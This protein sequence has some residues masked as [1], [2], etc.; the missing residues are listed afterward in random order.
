LTVLIVYAIIN[1]SN[2]ETEAETMQVTI[3]NK[4]F[5]DTVKFL[6]KNGCT[7]DYATK[8]W[9]VPYYFEAKA[10]REIDGGSLLLVGEAGPVVA[11]R[12]SPATTWMGQ[13]S[14]DAEDS[15]F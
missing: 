9:D 1:T 8:V 6:K 10:Q 2:R 12:P 13:A 15:I 11:S 14:M 3:T 5:A 7:C 4:D